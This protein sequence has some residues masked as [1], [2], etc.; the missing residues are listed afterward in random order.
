MPKF[1]RAIHLRF[2]FAGTKTSSDDT[3]NP[4]MYVRSNWTPPNWTLPPVVLKERLDKFSLTL[5]KLFKKR[6]GKTNLLLYQTCALQ[7]LQRQQDFL[8]C[9]CDK[10]LD[11][12]IIQQHDNIK[13][14]MRDHLLDGHTYRRLSDTD[15]IN[16]KQCLEQEV[17]SWI[18][19]YNK[20]QTKME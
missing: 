5:D 18:K 13:N 7:L 6:K 12:A 4:K 15:Y 8:I 14:A 10:N 1:Q 17:K 9:P 2:H 3:Y 20:T 16:H 19:T 11:P